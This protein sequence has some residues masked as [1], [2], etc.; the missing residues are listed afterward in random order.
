VI[1]QWEGL[2]QGLW[3]KEIDVRDF[4]QQNYEPY[5]G[6]GFGCYENGRG[7]TGRFD[8]GFGM[9]GITAWHYGGGLAYDLTE[10]DVRPFLSVGAGGVTPGMALRR[11]IS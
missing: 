8:G 6:N 3:Q 2:K 5:E 9:R 4:I 11:R 10:G 1:P 7:P